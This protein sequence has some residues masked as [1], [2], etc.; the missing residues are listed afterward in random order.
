MDLLR[1]KNDNNTSLKIGFMANIKRFFIKLYSFIRKFFLDIVCF[2]SGLLL[3]ISNS[4][5][6][7]LTDFSKGGFNGNRADMASVTSP[8]STRLIIF[9]LIVNLIYIFICAKYSNRKNSLLQNLII[10]LKLLVIPL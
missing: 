7:T 6:Y 9:I 10:T 2:T 4:L 8:Y 1:L 5:S 3:L